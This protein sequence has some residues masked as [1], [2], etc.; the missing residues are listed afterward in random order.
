MC[1]DTEEAAF[2]SAYMKFW[3]K[4]W[5]SCSVTKRYLWMEGQLRQIGECCHTV[6]RS[7]YEVVKTE[8]DLTLNEDHSSFEV[9]KMTVQ[10]DQLLWTKEATNAKNI[11]SRG[12]EAEVYER[13]KT[14]V[15]LLKQFH[16]HFYWLY[17]KSMTCTMVSLQGLSLGKAFSYPNISTGMGLKSFCP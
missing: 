13:K 5:A 4:V 10:T 6:W 8:Q 14:L 7:N 16:A 12:H 15:Q 1:S 11:N 3:K 17:E 9:N 2:N